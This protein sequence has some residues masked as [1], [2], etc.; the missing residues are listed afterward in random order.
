M[1]SGGPEAGTEN[2]EWGPN[3]SSPGKGR[4]VPDGVWGSEHYPTR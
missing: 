1:E 2:G 4:S 3:E